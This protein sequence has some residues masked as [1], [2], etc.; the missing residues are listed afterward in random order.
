MK[1]LKANVND[2]LKVFTK[3]ASQV[4]K[5][6]RLII[7]EKMGRAVLSQDFIIT[8]DINGKRIKINYFWHELERIC[9]GFLGPRR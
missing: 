4:E 5:I 1:E 7:I 3:V 8:I 2:L 9:C 6:T